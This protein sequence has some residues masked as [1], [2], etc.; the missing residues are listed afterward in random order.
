[1][2]HFLIQS[3]FNYYGFL[4]SFVYFQKTLKKNKNKCGYNYLSR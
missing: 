2:K 4:K 1:M 3:K